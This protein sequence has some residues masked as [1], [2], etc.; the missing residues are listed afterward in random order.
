MA[1]SINQAAHPR[2]YKIAKPA[3]GLLLASIKVGPFQILLVP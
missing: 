1:L 2:L 3:N